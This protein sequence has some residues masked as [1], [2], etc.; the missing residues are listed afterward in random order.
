M[1]RS[2]AC[3]ERS[4]YNKRE[5][6]NLSWATYTQGTVT[7]LEVR[8]NSGVYEAVWPLLVRS[9]V[10]SS[11]DC[12]LDSVMSIQYGGTS[13]VMSRSPCLMSLEKAR[14]LP[15]SRV[16]HLKE[17]ITYSTPQRT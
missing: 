10:S 7:L 14:T 6:N 5:W 2:T 11:I 12:A 13:N 9:H 15:S 1:A 8:V 4:V 16:E 17:V 3:P